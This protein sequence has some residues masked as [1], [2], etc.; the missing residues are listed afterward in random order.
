MNRINRVLRWF[1]LMLVDELTSN[2]KGE[3]TQRV[4]I[5]NRR[6]FMEPRELD[7]VTR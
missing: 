7:E 1:N 5:V 6:R 2:D 3:C 4:V